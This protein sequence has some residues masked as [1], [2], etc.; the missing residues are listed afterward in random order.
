[1]LCY[2]LLH[3]LVVPFQGSRTDGADHSRQLEGRLCPHGPPVL[4]HT[5]VLHGKNG[6][7]MNHTL[8]SYGGDAFK[9]GP[10]EK[11]VVAY[12]GANIPAVRRGWDGKGHYHRGQATQSPGYRMQVM[13]TARV[14]I[15]TQYIDMG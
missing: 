1:M 2:C 12:H 10:H 14:L 3:R 13:H 6:N 15:H 8:N 4:L 7:S 9:V 11:S 5:L